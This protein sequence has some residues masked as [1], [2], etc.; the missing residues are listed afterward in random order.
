M[1]R[2]RHVNVQNLLSV[3]AA[4]YEWAPGLT[5]ERYVRIYKPFPSPHI[6][7][8]DMNSFDIE[9]WL[10]VY[11]LCDG[12][13][14][15]ASSLSDEETETQRQQLALPELPHPGGLPV[16]SACVPS[17]MWDGSESS[18]PAQ[19][20]PS[21]SLPPR[22]CAGWTEDLHH[23]WPLRRKSV[24]KRPTMERALIMS[25]TQVRGIRT[26]APMERPQPS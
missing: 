16:H 11:W 3:L 14:W 26:A 21:S 23:L 19:S 1:T 20:H 24:L 7:I 15:V 17:T 5:E 8:M 2:T 12:S 10:W 6:S 25:T 9:F 18:I 13:W 22:S 4:G